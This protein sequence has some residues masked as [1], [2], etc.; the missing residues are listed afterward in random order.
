MDVCESRSCVNRFSTATNPRLSQRRQQTTHNNREKHR[1]NATL[2]LHA[3]SYSNWLYLLLFTRRVSPTSPNSRASSPKQTDCQVKM[4]SGDLAN[5]V[6]PLELI[7]KAI[8]S[9]IWVLMRGS[10]EVTGTLLGFDDYVR[11]HSRWI[12]LEE[13]IRARRIATTPWDITTSLCDSFAQTRAPELLCV[14]DCHGFH[15]R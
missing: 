6:L 2:L 4:A 8:G 7:D 15:R 5:Q 13:K 10:K 9:K 3:C 12:F 1:P 11:A 14:L